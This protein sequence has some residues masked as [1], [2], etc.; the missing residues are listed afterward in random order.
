MSI[1]RTALNFTMG[2]TPNPLSVG[3]RLQIDERMLPILQMTMQRYAGVAPDTVSTAWGHHLMK[4]NVNLRV[5][6]S[7]F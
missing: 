4:S 5:G 1:T 3:V 6:F 7:Q 2:N